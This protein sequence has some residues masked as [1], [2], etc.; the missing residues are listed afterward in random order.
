MTVYSLDLADKQELT[1][2]AELMA[3]VRTAAPDG[4]FLLVGAMARDLLLYH[5]HGIRVARATGCRSGAADAGGT[6]SFCLVGEAG[7][8]TAQGCTRPFIHLEEIS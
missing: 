4:R 2:L 6:Q 8:R 3:D 5:A 1:F 7:E